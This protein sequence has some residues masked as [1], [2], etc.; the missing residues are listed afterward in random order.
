MSNST[1]CE[2]CK[3]VVDIIR[4]DTLISNVTVHD[5]SLI[6][7]K[8]CFIL[9]GHIINKECQYIINNIDNI[10]NWVIRK[11]PT[12]EICTKLRM[13]KYEKMEL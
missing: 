8:L 11:M 4:A 7:S 5:I 3:S 12:K 10:Y 2:L 6:A 13:C 9:A 1:S